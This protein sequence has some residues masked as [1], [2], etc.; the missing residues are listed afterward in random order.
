MLAGG[1]FTG[2]ET[3]VRSRI[4]R[5]TSDGDLSSDF[6]ATVAIDVTVRALASAPNGMVWIGGDFLSVNGAVRSRIARLSSQ[7]ELDPTM[8]PLI[9]FDAPVLDLL[10]TTRDT[11]WVAG[12]FKKYR[13]APYNS[14]ARLQLDGQ[15][16]PIAASA[17]ANR[18]RKDAQGR[19]WVGGGVTQRLLADGTLETEGRFP[20]SP[21]APGSSL[22][23][24][25]P[26]GA[27]VATTVELLNLPWAP[28][29]ARL[30]TSDQLG[31]QPPRLLGDPTWTNLRVGEVL[32]AGTVDGHELGF[33]WYSGSSLYA[34]R[35]DIP[36]IVVSKT[37]D[38]NQPF[39]CVVS[40]VSGSVTSAPIHIDWKPPARF[41]FLALKENTLA[42]VGDPVALA[43]RA[44]G[45]PRPPR[46]RVQWFRG[47]SPIASVN[48]VLVFSAASQSDTD[49]YSCVVQNDLEAGAAGTFLRVV[50][51]TDFNSALD[52]QGWRFATSGPDA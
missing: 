23:T 16:L 37:L 7:G 29:V 13:G 1:A 19:V 50:E 10:L 9:G 25:T 40:N 33:R 4:A 8:D 43:C 12:R 34:Y 36:H 24:V 6:A 30:L 11:I 5:F 41:S 51:S 48:D 20:G 31:S 49:C 39:F 47:T 2:V 3:D 21:A 17:T 38:A 46:S 45:A 52:T 28:S 14:L 22:L 27:V 32:L 18:L 26:S 15:G 35:V 42:F 44:G